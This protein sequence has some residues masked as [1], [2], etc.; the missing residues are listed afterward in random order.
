M[1]DEIFEQGRVEDGLELE[2]L[3][4]NGRANDGEDAGADDRAD[5][6][7]GQTQR[8]ER[9][10]E[11]L[12]GVLRVGDQF[13]DALG[14]EKLCAQSAPSPCKRKKLYLA[15]RFRATLLHPRQLR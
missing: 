5:A 15:R 6:E 12:L 8:P 1:V 14:T 9:L 4:G 10:L 3:A 7:R 13:V 11:A 2:F